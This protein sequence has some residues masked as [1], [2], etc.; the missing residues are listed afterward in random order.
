MGSRTGPNDARREKS[1]YYR[2]SNHDPLASSPRAFAIPTALSRLQYWTDS[3]KNK[4]KSNEFY[5]RTF[6]HSNFYSNRCQKFQN[7][8]MFPKNATATC[9]CWFLARGFSTLK[10]DAIHSFETSVHTRSTLHH[11]PEDGI[12]HSH[13][14]ENLR[15][16]IVFP[17]MKSFHFISFTEEHALSNY[18][19][20][21]WHY[22]S[23]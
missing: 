6:L 13:R 8:I 22:T 3:G 15:S 11:I 16:Q 2:V 5:F 10:I 21:N 1:W 23:H 12:L 14:R 4:V 17:S 7:W 20:F 9:S 19:V 18:D